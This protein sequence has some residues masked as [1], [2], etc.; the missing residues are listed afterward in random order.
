MCVSNVSSHKRFRFTTEIASFV[1]E[2]D[3]IISHAG[4]GSILGA[5]RQKKRLIVV[6]NRQLMNNHQSE[7]AETMEEHRYLEVATEA[8]LGEVIKNARRSMMSDYLTSSVEDNHNVVINKSDVQKAVGLNS[9]PE[10]NRRKF[11]QVIEEET[12]VFPVDEG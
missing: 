12:G 11:W 8:N 4:A 1:K 3:L 5:L 7:L 9:Y 6:V 2:A 10:A